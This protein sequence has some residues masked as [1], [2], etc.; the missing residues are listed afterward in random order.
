VFFLKSQLAEL[1][2]ANARA[3]GYCEKLV[4]RRVGTGLATE[5]HR[6]LDA[7]SE[8]K[9]AGGISSPEEY[10][11]LVIRNS[12]IDPKKVD[13]D[14]RRETGRTRDYLE[15]YELVTLKAVSW[16]DVLRFMWNFEHNSPKYRILSID[17]LR[18]TD[19]KSTED[20]WKL[21]VRAAYRT[22]K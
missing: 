17:D 11:A 13:L 4:G 8:A 3:K 2:K 1:E 19:M 7:Y 5:V 9:K 15:K 21:Q 14:A 12:R 6:F 10:V 18:R 16:D 22:Q 20:S